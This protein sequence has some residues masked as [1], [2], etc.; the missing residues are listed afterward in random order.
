MAAYRKRHKQNSRAISKTK[1]L[2]NLFPILNEYSSPSKKIQEN[3][4]TL[5]G[6]LYY[7]NGSEYVG[8]YHI[9]PEIGP[10]VGATHKSTPHK[11][12]YY[13]KNLPKLDTGNS[14]EDFLKEYDKIDCYKCVSTNKGSQ[15]ISS[16]KSRMIGCPSGTYTTYEEALEACPSKTNNTTSVNNRPTE[17]GTSSSEETYGGGGVSSGGGGVS[18][19]GGT[20]G[21]GGGGY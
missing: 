20:S 16:T 18:S 21:G 13:I 4:N 9:H 5:G 1:N 3:L 8:P 14:Y 6:E 12:L 15:V 11:T 7:A 10:M 17:G 2:I 19:G